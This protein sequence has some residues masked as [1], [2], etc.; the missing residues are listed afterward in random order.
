MM[1]LYLLKGKAKPVIIFDI[2]DAHPCGIRGHTG[3]IFE[4]ILLFNAKSDVSFILS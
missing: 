1:T 2:D 4:V 3:L